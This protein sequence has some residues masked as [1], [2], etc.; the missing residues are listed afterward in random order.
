[1]HRRAP[2][3]PTWSGR[4]GSALVLVSSVSFAAD[5]PREAPLRASLSCRREVSPGRVQCELEVAAQSGRLAW[6]DAVVV[7][8]PEFA[9]PL[10]SRV[11][12]EQALRRSERA[13]TLP[14]AL[15]ATRSGRGELR[16]EARAVVCATRSNDACTPLTRVAAAEVEVGAREQR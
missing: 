7:S 14:L 11:G 1:M 4:L 2:R 16:V 9:K 8:V 10:R 12:P 5:P 13:T 3:E 15:A 6:A